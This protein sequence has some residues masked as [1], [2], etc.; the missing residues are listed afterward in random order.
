MCRQQA[1]NAPAVNLPRSEVSPVLVFRTKAIGCSSLEI[2]APFDVIG[3]EVELIVEHRPAVVEMDGSTSKPKIV[4]GLLYFRPGCSKAPSKQWNSWA[5]P[6]G[7]L[8]GR[9]ECVRIVQGCS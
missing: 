6:V 5:H 3:I 8:K 1:S 4:Q 2:Q 7:A 9:V